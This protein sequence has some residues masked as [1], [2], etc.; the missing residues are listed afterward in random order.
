MSILYTYFVLLIYFFTRRDYGSRQNLEKYLQRQST[1]RQNKN[2]FTENKLSAF[3]Q[4]SLQ[5]KYF[6]VYLH[7]QKGTKRGR[8]EKK[9]GEAEN[10]REAEVRRERRMT[11]CNENIPQ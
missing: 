6:G 3:I 4:M 9:R 8:A 7:S 2:H 5:N 1:E 11:D 10:G